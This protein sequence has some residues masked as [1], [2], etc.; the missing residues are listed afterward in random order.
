MFD[1]RICAQVEKELRNNVSESEFRHFYAQVEPLS[2]FH[3]V[4]Q[5]PAEKLLSVYRQLGLKTGDAKI[6][7]FCE[8]EEIEIFVT[9]NRHFLQ[10]L[11]ERSFEIVDSE[12]FCQV[13]SLEE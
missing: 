12:T 2:T 9:E 3:I 8:Q 6:A 4:Y 1:I 10:E 13:F 5:S 11:P 7:A